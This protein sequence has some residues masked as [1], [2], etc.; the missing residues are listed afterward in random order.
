MLD[1]RHYIPKLYARAGAPT[2][3]LIPTTM[4]TASTTVPVSTP[5]VRASTVAVVSSSTKAVESTSLKH[6]T[7]VA[8]STS[9]LVRDVATSK[10]STIIPTTTRTSTTLRNSSTTSNILSSAA[11]SSTSK[12]TSGISGGAIA[13]IVIGVLIAGLVAAIFL[14]RMIQRRR[15]ANR[16]MT[17]GLQ[18]WTNRSSM[19]GYGDEMARRAERE[20]EA[21]Q[22]PY[23][24][25]QDKDQD[26]GPWVLEEKQMY[27]EPVLAGVG[28]AAGSAYHPSQHAAEQGYPQP[29]PQEMQQQPYQPYPQQQQQQQ[30]HLTYGQTLAPHTPS[31]QTQPHGYPYTPSPGPGTPNTFGGGASSPTPSVAGGMNAAQTQGSAMAGQ[32]IQDGMSVVVRQGFIRT[33]EDELAYDDGWCLCRSVHG[34][35]GV[36]PQSCLE[37][38]SHFTAAS[39]TID[40]APREGQTSPAFPVPTIQMPTPAVVVVSEGNDE[41]LV[42]SSSE[43]AGEP[44]KLSP[45]ARSETTKSLA[46]SERSERR[47]SLFLNAAAAG[48]YLQQN[49][50]PTC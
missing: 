13:G 1:V 3:G 44:R 21:G 19:G 41:V 37:P 18:A 45:L 49:S 4:S 42:P 38:I 22:I 33:L 36:V 50:T 40:A 12:A 23:R 14:Y 31:H 29:Y 5:A 47:S 25:A 30:Q 10:M 9:S 32:V 34:E 2:A 26:G 6:N 17:G 20:V 39:P 46:V 48:L 11:A 15:R 27:H 35:Q 16:R 28:A 43:P 24:E 8:S 7:V